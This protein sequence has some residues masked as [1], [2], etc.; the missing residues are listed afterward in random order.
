MVS[1]SSR[2]N[3]ALNGHVVI[4]IS[5]F[6]ATDFLKLPWPGSSVVAS[7]HLSASAAEVVEHLS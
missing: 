5:F 1:T 7:V 2:F 6:C 3:A 4:S